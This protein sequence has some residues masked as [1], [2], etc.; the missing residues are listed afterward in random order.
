M[1][2]IG[3]VSNPSLAQKYVGKKIS[4]IAAEQQ[5]EPFAVYIDILKEDDFNS[6][7]LMHC[8]HEGNVRRTMQ[9]SRHTGGSDGI[10]TSTKPHPRGESPPR[11]EA[12][13]ESCC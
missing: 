7:I 2:E 3:G 10:I 11:P 6:T 9:H 1:L 8:G 4:E 12:A 5:R 13:A